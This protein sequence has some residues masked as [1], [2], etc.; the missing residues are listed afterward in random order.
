MRRS[1]RP[2]GRVRCP[3]CCGRT[4]RHGSST[5][6]D[7]DDVADLRDRVVLELLYATGIRVAELCGLDV[8]DVDPARSVLRVLGKGARER[9][10]ALRRARR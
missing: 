5:S 2:R 9:I 7:G 8:D 1:R 10:G 6:V 3:T 4:R